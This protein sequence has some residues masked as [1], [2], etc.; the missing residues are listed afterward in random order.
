MRCATLATELVGRGHYVGLIP[1]E[2]PAFV[3]DRLATGGVEI[4]AAENLSTAET[5]QSWLPDIVVVDGYHL[6]DWVIEAAYHQI[7]CVVIDD[8]HE[9]PVDLAALVVNQ[10]LHASTINYPLFGPRYLLGPEY[11]L[12]RQEVLELSEKD[13]TRNSAAVLVA[14]GGTDPNQLTVPVVEGLVNLEEV[15]VIDVALG[16]GH[17][18]WDRIADM[19]RHSGGKIRNA[20]GD[21]TESFKTVGSAVVG[22][23]STLWELA[24]LGIPSVAAIVADNQYEGSRAAMKIGLTTAVDV[25]KKEP[26]LGGIQLVDALGSVL[27]HPNRYLAMKM[28][29]RSIFDSGGAGRIAEAMESLS[30]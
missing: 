27:R 29:G 28:A 4:V 23:G 9:L 18:G 6:A 2:V 26:R 20:N 15:A 10:N 1:D 19:I 12:L 16:E 11:A 17:P 25:R 13:W 5:L 7:C 24:V 30:V 22:G 8:N 21:L 3:E 14:M